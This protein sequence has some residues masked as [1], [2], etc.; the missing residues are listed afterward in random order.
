[1]QK[2]LSQ[3]GLL[4]DNFTSLV[5]SELAQ[6]EEPKPGAVSRILIPILSE[7]RLGK[8]PR[9]NVNVSKNKIQYIQKIFQKY[10]FH[11]SL[12]L[13][14]KKETI[15]SLKVSKIK[16]RTDNFELFQFR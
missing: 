15:Y 8:I 1:M 7:A 6:L 12:L 10:H 2:E 14:I 16:L 5:F 11:A 9:P 3:A 13:N 4:P